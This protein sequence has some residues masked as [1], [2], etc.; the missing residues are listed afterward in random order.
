LE[1][2]VFAAGFRVLVAFVVVVVFAFGIVV[3][4][5]AMYDV[6]ALVAQRS[7]MEQGHAHGRGE[8]IP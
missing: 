1:A 4:V 8:S 5:H 2:I 7:R 3:A 6:I